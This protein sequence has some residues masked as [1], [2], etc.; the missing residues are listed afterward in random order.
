M[1]FF[2]HWLDKC[3]SPFSERIRSETIIIFCNFFFVKRSSSKWLCTY[4]NLCDENLQVYRET[5][6]FAI[7]LVVFHESS[8]SLNLNL[9]AYR[10][11][12]IKPLGVLFI[13]NTFKGSL[14]EP[15]GAYFIYQ[16]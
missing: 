4:F 7:L 5:I 14:V 15:K 3:L 1:S 12:S 9:F 16:R 10:K 11:S 13:S 8:L 6:L 2:A